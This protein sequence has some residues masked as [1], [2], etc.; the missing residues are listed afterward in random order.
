MNRAAMRAELQA[1]GYGSTTGEIIRQ[2]N[3]LDA[4]YLWVWNARD[5][6]GAPINWSFEH[7]D[8]ATLAVVGGVAA[9]VMPADFGDVD[10]IEDS[11]GCQLRELE[12]ELFDRTFAPGT[13]Q[14]QT[15]ARSWAFKVVNRQVTLGPTPSGTGSYKWSY[16]R[17]VSHY[18][19]GGT[20]MS[21]TFTDDGDSPLWPDHHL[22]LVW[23]A[24]LIGGVSTSNPFSVSF[25]G[26]RDD[27]LQQMRT[28]LEAEFAPAQVWGDGGWGSYTGQYG[29]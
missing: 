27:A 19:S 10:W 21:G 22:L 2:N 23:H 9:P 18:T 12:P 26:L 4:A 17:R 5:P 29:Y 15:A 1:I 11:Q 6:S 8:Q 13:S 7:V 20:V 16:R 14:G 28:D 25:Q 3:W 24:A